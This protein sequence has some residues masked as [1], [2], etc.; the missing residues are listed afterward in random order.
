MLTLRI[1]MFGDTV[2]VRSLSRFG[3]GVQDFTP[4]WEE[5]R[6]DF[7]VVEEE[8]FATLGARGGSPWPA[9]SPNYAAWKEKNF[10]GRPLMQLTGT[11]WGQ[12]AVGTG[13]DVVITPRS[14]LMTPTVPYALWHQKGTTYGLPIR[15]VIDLTEEDKRNWVRM[16]YNYVYDKAR[17]AHLA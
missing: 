6:Q 5:M 9:L 2:L 15:K 4:V 16:L 1:T 14:L 10:P 12:L 8:Q 13:L 7:A 3:E 11:M 17:E